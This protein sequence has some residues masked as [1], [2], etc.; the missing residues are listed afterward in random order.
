M[1]GLL[2]EQTLVATYQELEAHDSSLLDDFNK[3]KHARTFE[4]LHIRLLGDFLVVVNTRPVSSLGGLPRLQSLLTYLTLH[5]SVPQLRSRLAYLLWPDSTDAQA[6]TNLRNLLYK[7]RVMLPE[8]NAFLCIE[9]QTLCWR[10]DMLWSLDVQDF[11][12]ALSQ[13]E[14]A[15]PDERAE[16]QMLER[17][18]KLYQSDLLP[19][20]YEDWIC[21]ERDRLRQAYE[22]ALER[23]I[24]LFEQQGSYVVAIRVAQ[25]LLR[26]DPLRET[27]YRSLVCMPLGETEVR[28]HV[29]IRHVPLF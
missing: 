1:Q 25:R 12:Q 11:E 24:E 4:T 6:H 19:S 14:A 5:R 7:L 17:A 28:L 10:P 15:R 9:R 20:C 2:K 13:A 22:G 21:S 3:G 27:T 8:V 16:Q 23:L 18:M 26:S 29:R